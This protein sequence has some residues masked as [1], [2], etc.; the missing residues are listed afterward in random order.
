MARTDAVALVA[1]LQIGYAV[2]ARREG[3]LVLTDGITPSDEEIPAPGPRAGI[4]A[5]PGARNSA[6]HVALKKAG[7]R[8][9]SL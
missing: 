7:E 9:P 4:R 3:K 1:D 5:Y 2:S 8:H 6:C